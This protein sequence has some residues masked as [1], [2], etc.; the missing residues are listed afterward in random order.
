MND[1]CRGRQAAE[2][3]VRNPNETSNSAARLFGLTRQAV[4]HWAER[5]DV[6]PSLVDRRTARAAGRRSH[7]VTRR[8]THLV[9]IL[10][11]GEPTVTPFYDAKDALEFYDRAGAQWSESFLVEIIRGPLV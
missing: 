2:W 4:S 10:R 8:P 7:Q 5:L 3:L 9:V 6:K 11:E 1:K